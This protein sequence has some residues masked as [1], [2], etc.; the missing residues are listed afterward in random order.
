MNAP[1]RHLGLAQL[2]RIAVQLPF[3][4]ACEGFYFLRHGE[5][6]CNVQ[7]VF[8]PPEQPLNARG[9]G[10]AQQAARVL[11]SVPIT[12]I[13]SSDMERALQTAAAVSRETNV[14][15][16]SHADLRE[17]NFGVLV[18]TSSEIIDWTAA[19]AGGESLEQ[20]VLRSHRGLVAAIDHARPALVVAHGGTLFVLSAL[21]GMRL[22]D[23]YF[24]NAHPIHFWRRPTGE[25]QASLLSGA[26]AGESAF[27]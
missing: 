5:T 10:Q 3:A 15:A 18:G 22:G 1:R 7:K 17:R 4:V 16:R 12:A 27:A 14:P 24:S 21:L 8:Q 13:V 6:D 23:K 26:A 20:F 11:R 2:A 19:P 25:W 9:A